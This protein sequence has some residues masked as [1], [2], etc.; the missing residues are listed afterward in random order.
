MG[1][2]KFFRSLDCVM[3]KLSEYE[4][5]DTSGRTACGLVVKSS[6]EPETVL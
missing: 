5:N 4:M 3:A 1:F 6:L 2:V